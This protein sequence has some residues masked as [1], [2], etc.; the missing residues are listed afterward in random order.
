MQKLETTATLKQLRIRMQAPREF[1]IPR[2]M[3]NIEASA[4]ITPVSEEEL[5]AVDYEDSAISEAKTNKL[6]GVYGE[7]SQ[8]DKS[9]STLFTRLFPRMIAPKADCTTDQLNPDGDEYL[10]R[11]FDEAG[12]KKISPTGQL[13]D[14]REYR[15]RTFLVSGRRENL[16]MLATE[17]AQA[18]GY[19]SDLLF[20]INKSLYKIMTNQSEKD[21]LIDQGILT[22]QYRS[23][24]IA[25]VTAKSMFRQFGSRLVCDGHRI[26][27]DYWEAM[28]RRQGFTEQD[29]AGKKLPEGTTAA[30]NAWVAGAIQDGHAIINAATL[31][32]PGHSILYV[33]N[34]HWDVTA[35]DLSILFKH[36][37][38]VQS[39]EI[40]WYSENPR[41]QYQGQ[42]QMA[43]ADQADTARRGLKGRVFTLKMDFPL[44]I[45]QMPAL[46]SH[47]SRMDALPVE[48]VSK[49]FKCICKGQSTHALQV[50]CRQC[51]SWQHV[52][53][54]YKQ[55][56]VKPS[57]ALENHAC[58]ECEP[59][60]LNVESDPDPE[61]VKE[62][63]P[64]TNSGP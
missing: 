7:D 4:H 46:P 24:P 21:N 25:I 22:Y 32:P 29:L 10:P 47:L 48:A 63:A 55:E 31:I 59:R 17:C 53:C 45:S 39:C 56:S 38:E 51:A 27:D 34:L 6:R 30:R 3:V 62:T 8:A 35:A 61:A 52:N 50:R 60:P 43:T 14:G 13:L 54:Y 37:G 58:I 16:Y 11:E 40:Q 19:N 15:C 44:Y 64:P 12:E 5:K 33:T 49:R 20:N 36:Y 57:A 26:R 18:L 2:V 28:A 42:V 1:N 9:S 41:I 23:R